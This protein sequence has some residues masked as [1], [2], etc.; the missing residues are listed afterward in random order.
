[1]AMPS[2]PVTANLNEALDVKV[3]L[4][5]EFALDMIFLVNKLAETVNFFF[6]EVT[7]HNIRVD[8]SLG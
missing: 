1:M 6:S 2:T 3:N 4:F 8:A 7:R 5:S